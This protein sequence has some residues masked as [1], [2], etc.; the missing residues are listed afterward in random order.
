MSTDK[1]H[2]DT[3]LYQSWAQ[4]QEVNIKMI[5]SKY[6]KPLLW[7]R[8]TWKKGC[9]FQNINAS[10]WGYHQSL[11]RRAYQNC[12]QITSIHLN[13]ILQWSKVQLYRLWI[14][15]DHSSCGSCIYIYIYIYILCAIKSKACHHV[16]LKLKEKV[17]TC[18][19]L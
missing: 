9:V 16:I 19:F 13:G 11:W 7:N 10:T 12:S 6:L 4:I 8:L 3:I 18:L 17:H 2:S 14:S 1:L 15:F 5:K